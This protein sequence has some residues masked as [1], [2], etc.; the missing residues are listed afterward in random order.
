MF[1][2]CHAGVTGARQLRVPAW[3]GVSVAARAGH[4]H[5]TALCCLE[6]VQAL[7]LH[8]SVRDGKAADG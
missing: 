6:T 4:A 2:S 5:C 7:Q 1:N 3:L 8:V